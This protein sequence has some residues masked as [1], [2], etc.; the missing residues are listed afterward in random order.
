LTTE[1][2]VVQ[3][4]AALPSPDDPWFPP[5]LNDCIFHITNARPLLDGIVKDEGNPL[6]IRFKA[7]YGYLNHA[8]R[9]L[10]ITEYDKYFDG[11]Y[12]PFASF[13]ILPLLH[14]QRYLNHVQAGERDDSLTFMAQHFAEI[15]LRQLPN[16]FGVN[17]HWA[18]VIA[19]VQA[20]LPPDKRDQAL[21]RSAITA[22]DVAIADSQSRYPRYFATK[23]QLLQLAADWDGAIVAIGQAIDREDSSMADYAVRV[24]GYESLRSQIQAERRLQDFSERSNAELN[25]VR[26]EFGRVSTELAEMRNSTLT[27]VGLLAAVV[28]FITT[29]TTLIARLTIHDAIRFVMISSGGIIFVFAS[30][31]WLVTSPKSRSEITRFVAVIAV[32]AFLALCALLT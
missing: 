9:S 2:S 26:S 17:A 13:A 27:L 24:G 31:L 8:R 18:T 25:R 11:N 19:T 30:I 3:Q 12:G 22:E 28:A 7:F 16:H 6:E 14:S 20:S 4:L 29:N 5:K 23:A 10:D 32:A 1:R 15:A 21:I